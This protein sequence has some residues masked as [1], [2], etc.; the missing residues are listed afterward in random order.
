MRV[1]SWSDTPVYRADAKKSKRLVPRG[2]ESAVDFPVGVSD[3]SQKRSAPLRFY[4]A[5]LTARRFSIALER[6]SPDVDHPGHAEAIG[7]HAEARREERLGER[8]LH[9]SALGQGREQPLGLVEVR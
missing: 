1:P 2:G 6:S 9:L 3:A 8:H 7:H 5:S 4:E